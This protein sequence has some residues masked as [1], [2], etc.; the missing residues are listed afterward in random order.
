MEAGKGSTAVEEIA[1]GII[2]WKL[3]RAPKENWSGITQYD[4]TEFKLS[5]LVNRKSGRPSTGLTRDVAERLALDL[6][7]NKNELYDNSPYWEDFYI[8][9]GDGITTIDVSNP[10]EELL[11]R[12]LQAHKLVAF[13]HAELK[14][15]AKAL[16]VLYNDVDEAKTQNRGRN[17]KKLAYAKYAAMTNSEMVDVL[18]VMGERVVSTDEHIVEA[19]MG[20]LVEKRPAEFIDIFGDDNFKMKLFVVKCLHFDILQRGKGKGLEDMRVSFNGELLGE[21]LMAA[22]EYLSKKTNQPVFLALSKQME[23]ATGAGTLAGQ[24]ILSGYQIDEIQAEQ[25]AKTVKAGKVNSTAQAGAKP[26][27]GLKGG[28][29]PDVK[30]NKGQG[31]KDNVGAV[32][33][34]GGEGLDSPEYEESEL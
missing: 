3:R 20:R 2:T 28:M 9:I 11:F 27:L 4:H 21:G 22:C 26:G 33:A 17:A 7:L 34:V 24:A 31:V 1:N 25:G 12:F 13:G 14:K 23:I 18:M 16:F 30:S 6:G 10:E 8:G 5:C 19:M 32:N 29:K 15:N